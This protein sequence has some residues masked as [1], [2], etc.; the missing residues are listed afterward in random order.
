M[1]LPPPSLIEAR[2]R[3]SKPPPPLSQQV[4]RGASYDGTGWTLAMVLLA[5]ALLT[6]LGS[7]IVQHGRFPQGGGEVLNWV[8]GL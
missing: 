2:A 5:G 6:A 4:I 3:R 8:V 7:F 1:P